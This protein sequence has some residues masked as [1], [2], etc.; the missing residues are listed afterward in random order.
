MIPGDDDVAFELFVLD[1]TTGSRTRVGPTPQQRAGIDWQ[2]LWPIDARFSADGKWVG[3]RLL[4][5]T[6]QEL[7]LVDLAHQT[8]TTVAAWTRAKQARMLRVRWT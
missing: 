8:T 1:R 5:L 6:G 4:T 7:R 3:Y 2:S